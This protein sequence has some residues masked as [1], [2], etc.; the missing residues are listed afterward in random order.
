M[1]TTSKLI[2]G[3]LLIAG[4][5]I[6]AGLLALPVETGVFGFMPSVVVLVSCWVA[7][8]FAA[9]FMLEAN[10]WLPQDSNLISMAQETLGRPG[11]LLAWISYLLLLYALMVAYL[12][13]MNSLIVHSVSDNFGFQLSP[14]I[15][16]CSLVLVFGVFLYFGTK[17]IDY[18]NRMLLFGMGS[19]FIALI[20]TLTPSIKPALLKPA[21]F[22]GFWTALPVIVTTFGYQIVI[23]SVRRYLKSDVRTMVITIVLGSTIPLLIY[24]VWEFMI[25]G[26]I[27]IHGDHGLTEILSTGQPAIGLTTSLQGLLHAEW[28]GTVAKFLSFFVIATSFIGVSLSLFDFLCDGFHI[29]R[30]HAGR[31]IMLGATFIPPIIFTLRYPG[32]FMAAL[33]YAGILVAVLLIIIPVSMVISGRYYRNEPHIFRTP[34]GLVSITLLLIFALS[35]I[36]IELF[37]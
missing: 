3:V 10:L 4:T 29:D 30:H 15:S 11:K 27:P 26:V 25:L 9:F 21:T 23:P 33:G 2:G 36:F 6:G 14:L 22:H 13:G 34:G 24:L 1:N 17:P 8:L 35:V 28:I 31:F 12:S 37:S 16:S 20:F 32:A 19:C 18:L 7:T 5:S